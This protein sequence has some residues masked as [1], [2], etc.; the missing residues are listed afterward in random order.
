MTG[1]PSSK[2]YDLIVIGGGPGGTATAI[3]A[4][5]GKLKTLV[6]D[7]DMGQGAMG[8]EHLVANYP[9]FPEPVKADK[10]LSMM[11]KQAGTLGATYLQDKVVYTDFRNEVKLVATPKE[12]FRTKAVVIATG[13][14]GREPSIDGER[15]F[16]GR[17]VAY[18]AI[19]DGAY[20]ERKTVAVTGQVDRVLEE[21]NLIS[22]YAEKILFLSPTGRISD[23]DTDRISAFPKVEVLKGHR[24][25]RILGTMKVE[26]LL[27]EGDQ[28]ERE[29]PVDGIF[30]YLQG[31]K[32]GV[33]FLVDKMEKGENSCL[34]VDGKMSTSVP[35]VFAVG[36]VT[37]RK[38][39]QVSLAV[40]EGCRAALAVESYIN[41][42]DG[43]HSQWGVS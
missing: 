41:G 15:D 11:R 20:F 3:Y 25:K 27:L 29:L 35:G 16:Q 2:I 40:G 38:V 42:R 39:R 26:A 18:C 32:P 36:D 17:G 6:I 34:V 22:K 13:S 33:E 14:M 1:E 19:C 24:I 21:I 5:R 31:S 9:G 28:G 7:K 12:K 30:I 8:G 4:S 37:C 10:L 23:K 43:A